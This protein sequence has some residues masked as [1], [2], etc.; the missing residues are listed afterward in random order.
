MVRAAMAV[1]PV[2]VVTGVLG[3]KEFRHKKLDSIKY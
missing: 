1:N 3:A 2:A